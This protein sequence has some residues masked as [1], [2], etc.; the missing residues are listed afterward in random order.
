MSHIEQLAS[1]ALNH[2]YFVFESTT[3]MMFVLPLRLLFSSP[4][5][6]EVTNSS[7]FVTCVCIDVIAV[8]GLACGCVAS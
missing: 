4:K 3:T 6:S 8:L 1:V 2:A 7:A 5:Q